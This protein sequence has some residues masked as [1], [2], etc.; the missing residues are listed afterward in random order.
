MES[1]HEQTTGEPTKSIVESSQRWGSL[2]GEKIQVKTKKTQEHEKE[3][4]IRGASDILKKAHKCSTCDITV[5]VESIVR[6]RGLLLGQR[7]LLL[8]L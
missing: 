3:P 7:L 2:G 6:D 4:T 8:L 5:A 1:N